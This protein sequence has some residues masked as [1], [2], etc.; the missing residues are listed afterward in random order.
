MEGG[1]G[2]GG[3]YFSMEAILSYTAAAAAAAFVNI[4]IMIHLTGKC[5]S[6]LMR[7]QSMLLQF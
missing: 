5:R 6:A 7:K 4:A 3:C 1:G 2:R